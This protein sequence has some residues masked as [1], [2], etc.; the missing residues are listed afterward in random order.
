MHDCRCQSRHVGRLHKQA[1]PLPNSCLSLSNCCCRS[2]IGK[3]VQLMRQRLIRGSSCGPPCS[4]NTLSSSS[5]HTGLVTRQHQ[6]QRHSAH[7]THMQHSHWSRARCSCCSRATG[8]SPLGQ[9]VHRPLSWLWHRLL[10]GSGSGRLVQLQGTW[11]L[12][13]CSHSQL[14]VCGVQLMPA[15]IIAQ[16]QRRVQQRRNTDCD[17]PQLVL[18]VRLYLMCGGAVT[19]VLHLLVCCHIGWV[20]SVECALSATNRKRLH[21]TR[22]C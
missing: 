11:R 4:H 3:G 2:A 12:A 10:Q 1:A 9:V 7:T 8:C 17:A 15:G 5:S 22:V 21:L 20:L 13:S 18:Y 19:S 6:Q 16:Y 14:Q